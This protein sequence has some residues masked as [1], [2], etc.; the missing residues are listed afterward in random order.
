M[1]DNK[2]YT[3]SKILIITVWILLGSGTVV[4]LIAAITKK[5]NEQIAGIKINI[6]GVQSNYF[7]DKKDVIKILEKAHGKKLEKAVVSSL[8][9]SAMES[10]LLKDQWIKRSEMFFDNNNVLQVKVSERE[11]VA[12]IFTST[13][14]SFYMDSSLTRLPLS[15]KFSARLPVFTNFPTEV[16]VLIKQDSVLL[17]EIKI[18]S[19]FIGNDPFW[20]AQIDQVDIT[21]AR[22]F[23]LIPKLGNQV[24]R[25]GNANNYQEKFN[26]LFAFY[27][28]V[29]TRTGWNRYSI[30]DLQFSNQIVAVSRD[31]KEIKMDSLRSIQIMKSIIA[32]AQKSTND[33]THIQLAQPDDDNTNINNSPVI[34]N[35]LN[36]DAVDNKINVEKGKVNGSVSSIHVPEKTI[37]KNPESVKAKPLINHPTSNEKPGFAQ[38]K[39]MVLK[40][41]EP[42]KE[43][44]KKPEE[45]IKQQPKAVMPLK[46]DY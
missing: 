2:K 8:D 33:S 38:V 42:K 40:K 39:K 23:E 17:N 27:K 3:F 13:G 32:N 36:E 28:Q 16:V 4:L 11:P 44:L 10:A 21:T 29:Q 7:I 9:L 1:A 37:L 5:N 31:A 35:V 26:K 19:E 14:A 15:D 22:T 18:L 45:K 41:T 24:I 12:R 46:S 43:E 6:T 30:L 25:F 34:E 20:M